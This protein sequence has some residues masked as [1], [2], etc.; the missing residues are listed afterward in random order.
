MGQW[1]FLVWSLEDRWR[2]A[3]LRCLVWSSEDRWRAV[4]LRWFESKA[5]VGASE[6]L[7]GLGYEWVKELKSMEAWILP[8]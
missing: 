4:Q 3:Q 8:V 7:R 2:A 6:D 5:N 1:L